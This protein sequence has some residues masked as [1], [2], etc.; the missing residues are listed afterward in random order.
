MSFKV[1]FSHGKEGEEDEEVGAAG[2]ATSRSLQLLEKV[3]EEAADEDAVSRLSQDDGRRRKELPVNR[4]GE[5]GSP[6]QYV[7]SNKVPVYKSVSEGLNSFGWKEIPKGYG[8]KIQGGAFGSIKLA[9]KQKDEKVPL[10]SRHLAVMKVQAI[11]RYRQTWAEV[12]ILKAVVHENIVDFYGVFAYVPDKSDIRDEFDKKAQFIILLEY[13]A[14]GDMLREVERYGQSYLPEEGAKYYLHQICDGLEYLHSKYIVHTDIHMRNIFLKYNPDNSTKRCLVADFGISRIIR[15]P[16]KAFT[17]TFKI[18]VGQVSRMAMD[19]MTKGKNC[20]PR[21]VIAL[22]IPAQ[23]L[24]EC[25]NFNAPYTIAALRK[26]KFFQTPGIPPV[27]PKTATP[28]LPRKVVKKI[29]YLNPGSTTGTTTAAAGASS[30]IEDSIASRAA[31]RAVDTGLGGI[32][33]RPSLAVR[34]WN[35]VNCF[36]PRHRS[37]HGQ[38]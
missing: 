36:R 19:M 7:K 28:L 1:T 25:M 21:P 9:Y 11:K 34:A 8:P 35:A 12:E 32:R 13:C 26:L 16:E 29:G 4:N 23:E 18:D 15:N 14:A 37:P 20:R 27:P 2:G 3:H 22:S 30:V 33:R 10:E 38:H 6:D 31:R 17:N 24:F 5:P